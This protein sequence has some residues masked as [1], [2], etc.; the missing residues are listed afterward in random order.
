MN[1]KVN[2]AMSN[3]SIIEVTPN[4]MTSADVLNEVNARMES[5]ERSV[6]NIALLCAYGTGTTIPAY[7]DIQGVEHGEATIEKPSRQKDF[8]L[9]VNRSSKAISR[10][11]MA[12][13]LIIEKGLFGDFANGVYPFSYDKIIAILR[14]ENAFSN[15]AFY[16]AMKLSAKSLDDIAKAYNSKSYADTDATTAE[17]GSGETDSDSDS[18]EEKGSE[19]PSAETTTL[20]YNGKE[21]TVNK[22]AFEKWLAENMIAD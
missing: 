13:N 19:E 5:V 17:K 20:T 21:Y 14:N 1:K 10:W 15:M 11:I 3:K 9:Q 2:K 8:I 12:M 6:F 7:T 4:G 16:D 18:K 22:Q